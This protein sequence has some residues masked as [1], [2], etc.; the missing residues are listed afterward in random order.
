MTLLES[1]YGPSTSAVLHEGEVGQSFRTSV[2]VHQG[3]LLSPELFNLY[4]ENI[5][6]EALHNFNGTTSINGREI[7]NLRFADDIDLIAGT[8]EE[9]Q[10]LTTLERRARAYGMEISAEKSKIM[11][12]SRIAPRST[13]LMNGERLEE[14]RS[15]KYFGS[16]ISSE[17]DSTA[18]IRTRINLATSAIA[19]LKKIWSN[20][21]IKTSTKIRLYKSLVV[22]VLTCGCGRWTPKAESER[23]KA[24]FEMTFFRRILTISYRDHITNISVMP[25]PSLN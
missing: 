2:G 22:S 6:Q 13:I 7:S 11:V 10:E 25:S 23:R 19:R 1:L 5:I 4:L 12:N 15:F 18:E 14:V 3:C 24:A 21:N 8:E 17:G 16:I 20:N 9:L